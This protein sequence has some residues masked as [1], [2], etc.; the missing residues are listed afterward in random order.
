MI[1]SRVHLDENMQCLDPLPVFHKSEIQ[2]E[3]YESYT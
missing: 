3:K 1:I 2:D